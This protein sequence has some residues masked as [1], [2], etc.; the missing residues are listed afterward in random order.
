M[1]DES[2]TT[3][4]EK[5]Q[6]KPP[7]RFVETRARISE[8]LVHWADHNLRWLWRRLGSHCNCR[9]R[10][11]SQERIRESYVVRLGR[12]PTHYDV[13]RADAMAAK[14]QDRWVV[15]RSGSTS[16]PYSGLRLGFVDVLCSCG[17]WIPLNADPPNFEPS[18]STLQW[19][20]PGMRRM[21]LAHTYRSVSSA[22]R[23]IDQIV[24]RESRIRSWLRWGL[25]LVLVGVTLFAV[26]GTNSTP[27][28]GPPVDPGAPPGQSAQTDAPAP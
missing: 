11:L 4:A 21:L 10:L 12:T 3:A 24:S 19:T 8:K 16:V 14:G 2:L 9:R 7:S 25:D 18:G 15:V 6:P 5:S 23:R 13:A 26:F 28:S 1:R 17:G 27:E 22:E 20:D